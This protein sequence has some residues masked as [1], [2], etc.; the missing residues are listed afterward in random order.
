MFALL[1]QKLLLCIGFIIFAS[2]SF[3]SHYEGGQVY[4]EALGN[5]RY[6]F[7]AQ[8]VGHTEAHSHALPYQLTV[9]TNVPGRS[10]I[11]L[12]LHDTERLTQYCNDS[13]ERNLELRTFRSLPIT[14]AAPAAGTRYDFWFEDCCRADTSEINVTGYSDVYYDA[15]MWHA[16]ANKSSGY[17]NIIN[18][19]RNSSTRA[20]DVKPN[21]G[22]TDSTMSV[23]MAFAKTQNGANVTYNTGYSQNFPTSPNDSLSADGMFY[24]GLIDSSFHAVLAFSGYK[25]AP[26]GVG[27]ASVVRYTFGLKY[28]DMQYHSE[29][30]LSQLN[31]SHAFDV[32]NHDSAIFIQTFRTD[33]IEIEFEVR[34]TSSLIAAGDSIQVYFSEP[35]PHSPGYSSLPELIPTQSSTALADTGMI[36]FKFRWLVPSDLPVG[37]H[38]FDLVAENNRCPGN[39]LTIRSLFFTSSDTRVFKDYVVCPNV[40][41]QLNGPSGSN[42][43]WIPTTGLNFNSGSSRPYATVDSTKI[44]YCVVNGDTV[45]IHRMLVHDQTP[46][47]VSLNGTTLSIDNP[48]IYSDTRSLYFYKVLVAALDSNITS[49]SGDGDY[50]IKAYDA[51][52]CFDYS[53]TVS[54][55]TSSR[56]EYAVIDEHVQSSGWDD[57]NSFEYG[58]SFLSLPG[59]MTELHHMLL[60]GV[61]RD[62]YAQTHSIQ[63]FVK[64]GQVGNALNF[65]VSDYNPS[66]T[67]ITFN[68]PFVIDYTATYRFEFALTGYEGHIAH[69]F[70]YSTPKALIFNTKVNNNQM[71]FIQ[72]V[73][74]GQKGLS[75]AELSNEVSI[76]PNP[77]QNY[78]RISGIQENTS[79]EIVASD[80]STVKT[81]TVEPEGLISTAELKSGV[82][83]LRLHDNRNHWVEKLVIAR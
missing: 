80:G 3:A 75:Q 82:Y 60:P 56:I 28:I 62:I 67:L 37:T 22:G 42:V 39:G 81:G 6:I 53:N 9:Y 31:S 34:D 27:L 54:L 10:T 47:T 15:Y 13:T 41:T 78:V 46:L 26:N 29:P 64:I 18:T 24:S 50:S 52:R 8:L 68:P 55:T 1:R 44:Y 4:W 33:T 79:F 17:F 5:D 69:Q 32:R 49:V 83:Y 63:G 48:S 73:F 72:I 19:F 7:Y 36:R 74:R 14:L 65:S 76:F 51:N 57:I 66:S 30:K 38:T 21:P 40:P 25:P 59:N 23:S 11:L 2:S 16:G 61:R 70:P 45:E 71:D 35:T 43:Q 58:I 20:I 77:A 12:A